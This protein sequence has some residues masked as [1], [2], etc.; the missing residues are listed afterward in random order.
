MGIVIDC[1]RA[2]SE[3]TPCVARD[4]VLATCRDQEGE[5]CVGCEMRVA[6]MFQELVEQFAKIQAC[7]RMRRAP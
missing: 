3:M 5:I 1:P 7:D 4:G 2:K 6:E